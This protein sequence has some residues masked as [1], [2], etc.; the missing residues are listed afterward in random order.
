M[1]N[2]LF[3]NVTT[4][5][6]VGIVH[7]KDIF[8]CILNA[9]GAPDDC[10]W[11]AQRIREDIDYIKATNDNIVSSVDSYLNQIATVVDFYLLSKELYT[12]GKGEE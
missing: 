7:M 10:L 12:K 4:K 8:A 2:P 9:N 5:T 1:D 11:L 6:L 3:D